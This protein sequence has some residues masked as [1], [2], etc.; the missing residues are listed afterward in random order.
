LQLLLK[1]QKM[2]SNVMPAIVQIG[3]EQLRELMT[4]VKETL[5][6][7]YQP[8]VAVIKQRSF[9]VTDLWNCR[10]NMRTAKSLRRF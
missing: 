4:E 5:A 3:T 8:K 7:D 6:M 1:K 9:G 10:K 2:K